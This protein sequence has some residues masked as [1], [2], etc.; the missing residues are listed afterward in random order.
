MGIDDNLGLAIAKALLAAGDTLPESGTVFLSVRDG[1]KPAIVNVASQLVD[2][3]FSLVATKGTARY[4]QDKGID[5]I[6]VN[7]I[8]E[9]RPHIL[10]KIQDNQ[11]CW[12]VNT[13]MGKRTTDDSYSIR[14]AALE[15]HIPYTTTAA[16][17]ISVVTSIKE[18]R[19]TALG[20]QPVQYFA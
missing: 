15:L 13:S 3:G 5:C 12:V 11:I 2:L 17:A 7:K 8:S 18:M 9:G 1:D 19:E 16:G 6:K 4:L 14:R 20:V 10:D